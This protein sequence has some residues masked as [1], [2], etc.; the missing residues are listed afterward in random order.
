MEKKMFKKAGKVIASTMFASLLIFSQTT[1][2]EAAVVS[3]KVETNPQI[4]ILNNNV[5]VSGNVDPIVIDGTTYLPVRALSG[6]LNKIVT[7]DGRT[8][9]IYISDTVAPNDLKNEISN[10]ERFIKTKDASIANLETSVKTK[11]AKIV[12][13]ENAI[14]TKDAKIA[15][16][17]AQLLAK[18]K[19]TVSL[20]ELD[21][22]LNKD[23]GDW[24]GMEFEITLKGDK[25]DI[26]VEI[27][28]DLNK[29]SYYRDW[30]NLSSTKIERFI[31]S[32]V[33]D[34]WE[35]YEDAE[36]TGEVIDIDEDETLVTFSGNDGDL[37]RIRVYEEK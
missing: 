37:K 36:I 2:S 31:N 28:I 30:Y 9:S 8:K 18:S 26:E 16:L 1:V 4:K 22:Q 19:S 25:D 34:I 13:L 35:E 17:E 27:E 12:E 3:K 5:Q 32:I 21:K 10:L 24:N 6:V 15:E 7:W 29:R 23:Y 11:D 14:K 20:K 33:D